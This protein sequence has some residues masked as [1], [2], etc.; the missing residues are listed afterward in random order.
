VRVLVAGGAGF[1]GSHVCRALVRRGHQVICIDDLSTG[2]RANVADLWTN[3]AFEFIEQDVASAPLVAADAILHLASPASPVDYERLQLETL[4]ANSKGT[5]RLAAIALEARAK[6]TYAT[7]SQVYGDPLVHPQPETYRGNV[8]TVG[9]RSMYDEGKRFGEALLT[10]MRRTR[11]LR[12]SIVRIFNTYGPD[13]RRDDGRVIPELLSA[14]LANRPLEV[15]G[16]GSQTRSF[17]YVDDLV[18]GLLLVGLDLG[19]DGDVLNLGNPAE[20]SIRGLAESIRELTGTAAPIVAAAARPEDPRQ[21]RPDI[22]RI[23][24]RYGWEP[25]TDLREGL[26]RTLEAWRREDADAARGRPAQ[27]TAPAPA[28]G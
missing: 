10:A 18:E 25:R 1:V 2:S 26:A 11:G 12:A 3:S 4:A 8:D 23:R 9:P 16:D 14:A 19:A 15:H 28:G 22:G 24:A 5:W 27:A 13:M 7:T 17:C 6:L 20:I 21:R